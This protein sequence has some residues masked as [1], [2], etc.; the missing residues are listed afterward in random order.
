MNPQEVYILESSRLNRSETMPNFSK[1]MN[2]HLNTEL[3]E[4]IGIFIGD[5]SLF[6]RENKHD[7][8]FKIVG[9]PK[10]EKEYYT[11][12]ARLSSQIVGRDI[13]PKMRDAGRSYGIQFSSKA[14]ANYLLDLGIQNKHKCHTIT[15]PNAILDNAILLKHCLKGI[16]DTDGCLTFKKK[17]YPAIE[18]VSASM[19]LAHQVDKILN[20]FGIGHCVIFN[21][22][23]YDKRTSKISIRNEI[24]I[25]GFNRVKTFYKII[26][27]SNP[28]FKFR[29]NHIL[30]NRKKR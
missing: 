27:S 19:E 20:K 28:K 6:I 16:F 23:V 13:Q 24:Y 22:K 12:V 11:Y 21:R 18:F 7:Y 17:G 29:Y 14:F 8:A 30:E 4:F 3:A 5:G 1:S 9:N 15:I 10:D 26:G 25:N 2:W